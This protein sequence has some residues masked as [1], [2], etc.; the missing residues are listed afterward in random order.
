[1][2][3]VVL[4]QRPSIDVHD[5]V[6][7]VDLISRNTDDTLDEVDRWVHRVAEHDN[8][9]ALDVA[10]GKNPA[11]CAAGIGKVQLIGQKEIADEQG[12]FHRLGGHA[13]SLHDERDHKHYNYRDGKERREIV[14]SA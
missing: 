2:H 6:L 1:M 4:T 11:P 5:L 13:K 8:V 14:G 7:Q 12:V 9:T 10:V 3:R